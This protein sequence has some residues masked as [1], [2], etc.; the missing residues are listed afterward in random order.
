MEKQRNL[1]SLTEISPIIRLLIVSDFFIMGAFGLVTPIFALFITD[2]ISGATVETV[3][4][5]MTIY[6]VT[7]SLGQMPFGIVIDKIKGEK[8]DALILII[9]SCAF[10]GVSLSYLFIETAFQLYMVQLVYG[11]ISAASY[12]TWYAL[13]TRAIDPGKEGMEWSAYQTIIDLG[14]AMTASVGG[15]VASQYGFQA[16]FIL[17]AILNGL[18]CLALIWAGRIILDD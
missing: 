5:A 13:F 17:M 3:G 14:G 11:L 10:V 12:P 18:G 8:D 15:F 16:V 4:I 6:L 2:F 1:F 9:S 7:R